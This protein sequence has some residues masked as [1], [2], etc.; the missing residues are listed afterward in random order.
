MRRLDQI[1]APKVS[2][3]FEGTILNACQGDSVATALL[4]A[5]HRNLRQTAISN[6]ARGPYCMMGVCFDC[7]VEIDGVANI[8]ACMTEVVE[9][10]QV[11]RQNGA[12]DIIAAWAPI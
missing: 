1:N 10:M 4:A 3:T 8:Q 11:S 2:F 5:G 6:A 12:K 9:G 7:L